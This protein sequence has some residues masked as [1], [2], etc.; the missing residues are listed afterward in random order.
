MTNYFLSS[1]G[2][3]SIENIGINLTYNCKGFKNLMKIFS[4]MP[5]ELGLVWTLFE[6]YFELLLF[7]N[8]LRKLPLYYLVFSIGNGFLSID[9]I[10]W[11]VNY[12]GSKMELR[13]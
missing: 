5:F 9:V 6:R 8:N 2:V 3:V 13:T 11:L 1:F 7:L 12:N 4:L 10:S